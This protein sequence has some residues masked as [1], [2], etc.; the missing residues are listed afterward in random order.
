MASILFLLVA[1][2]N[3]SE[4]ESFIEHIQG[5]CPNLDLAFAI[6]DNSRN[7][8]EWTNEARECVLTYRPDNPGYLEGALLA[9]DAYLLKNKSVPKWTFVS[10][11][12]LVLIG[13]LSELLRL[14][15]PSPRIPCVIAPRIT[16]GSSELDMNPHEISP[17]RT[18][19]KALDVAL[20]WTP[21]LAVTYLAVHNGRRASRF[22][23]ESLQSWGT[24]RQVPPAGMYSPYGA[25]FGLSQAFIEQCSLPR[26][27]P[28][29]AEEFAIAETARAHSA[30]VVYTPSVHFFHAANASTGLLPSR[31]RAVL[32][33]TAF[34][35]IWQHR[36][37]GWGAQGA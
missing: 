24:K 37:H 2:N 22:R 10:N 27:V 23:R 11:T 29:F 32:L 18:W 13:G 14:D 21:R 6:C 25:I 31:E 35:Y 15:D 19:R 3:P 1:H 20:T 12:D 16:E 34:R 7:P 17:R 8:V 26:R 30:P 9:L 5:R 36:R 28:L 4:V 33:S